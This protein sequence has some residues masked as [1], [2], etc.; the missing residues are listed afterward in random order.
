M[1]Y[2]SSPEEHLPESPA[3]E[4]VADQSSD[5]LLG[6]YRNTIFTVAFV[7][8]AALTFNE[9]GPIKH[10]LEETARW[11]V[12]AIA[13]S[14]SV[15]TAGLAAM[16]ASTGNKIGNPLTL[17]KRLNQLKDRLGGSSLYRIGAYL[18]LAGAAGT[19]SVITAETLK[20]FPPTVW[21]LALGVAGLST[22]LSLP[23]F[24]IARRHSQTEADQ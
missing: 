15:A 6:R 22:A 7:G 8:A 13:S 18:N 17:R 23:F 19:S 2:K 16:I 11:T 9:L 14:E 12:P 5:S 4:L 20:D 21:P 10:D 24:R 3:D 1:E